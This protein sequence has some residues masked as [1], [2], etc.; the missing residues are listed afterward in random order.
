MSIDLGLLISRFVLDYGCPYPILGD[1][2]RRPRHSLSRDRDG[3]LVYGWVF[4]N[5]QT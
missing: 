5:V 2:G 3:F 1:N 4:L